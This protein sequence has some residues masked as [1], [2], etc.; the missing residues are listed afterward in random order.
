MRGEQRRKYRGGDSRH[1]VERE[2]RLEQRDDT[3][4]RILAEQLMRVSRSAAP[5]S[6]N[7]N[8]RGGEGLCL[9]PLSHPP[10]F[11]IMQR[12]AN[13]ADPKQVERAQPEAESRVGRAVFAKA[14]EQIAKAG[15]EER[16]RNGP[17]QAHDV[18]SITRQR[19]LAR[20]RRRPACRNV[21]GTR[22]CPRDSADFPRSLIPPRRI[23]V[24]AAPPNAA[25]RHRTGSDRSSAQARV[26]GLK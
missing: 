1:E 6:D 24:Q 22:R 13:G 11:E 15:R 5:M 17:A 7:K 12:R 2:C 20:A 9:N 25:A 10:L 3:E 26:F 16:V 4:L 19:W 8:G 23:P 18:V 14:I 21:C